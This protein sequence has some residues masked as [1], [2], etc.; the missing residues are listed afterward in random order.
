M[1]VL[2][3]TSNAIKFRVLRVRVRKHARA[4][5]TMHTHCVFQ[6]FIS[7]FLGGQSFN[8]QV[9][10]PPQTLRNVQNPLKKLQQH[11]FT[12]INTHLM[13][14]IQT[15]VRQSLFFSSMFSKTLVHLFKTPTHHTCTLMYS[16]PLSSSTLRQ[17]LVF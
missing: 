7:S 1:V 6:N 8:I 9:G 17:K 3:W 2:S 4:P 5:T 13:F 15:L 16:K 11:Q 10:L 12:H 14:P